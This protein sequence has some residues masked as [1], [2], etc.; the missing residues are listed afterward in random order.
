[1]NTFGQKYPVMRLI[2]LGPPGSGKST[3]ARMLTEHLGL[4]HIATGDLMRFHQQ[5]GTPFGV[6][7]MEYMNHGLLVPDEIPIAMV[8]EEVLPPM[9]QKGFLLDGFPRN[10]VQAEALSQALAGRGLETDLAILIKVPREEVLKRLGGRFVCQKCQT[11][12]QLETRPPETDGKCD[13]C[14]GVLY[15]RQ[16]DT[17]EAVKVRI[18]VYKQETQPLVEY[19]R[20]MGKMGEVNGQGTVDEVNKRVLETLSLRAQTSEA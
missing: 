8:L 14:G 9:G 10:L 18:S 19:Y 3:Q 2:L 6:K 1:M 17:L 5:K 4:P 20:A 12:Y 16:D 11:P 15:Q 7:A 13:R